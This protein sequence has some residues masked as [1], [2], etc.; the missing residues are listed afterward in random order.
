MANLYNDASEASAIPRNGRPT[1]RPAYSA[2]V[3]T[4]DR[5]LKRKTARGITPRTEVLLGEKSF[6]ALRSSSER[7]ALRSFRENK[8]K[9]FISKSGSDTLSP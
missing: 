6:R 7:I 9:R 4:L 1:R 5:S 8:S 2:S 3:N